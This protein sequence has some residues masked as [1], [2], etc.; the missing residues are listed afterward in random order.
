MLDPIIAAA[1]PDE[2]WILTDLG[3]AA[4]WLS[5]DSRLVALAQPAV[6]FPKDLSQAGTWTRN[7][8]GS[9]TH[10][11][12]DSE[13]GAAADTIVADGINGNHYILQTI[14]TLLSGLATTF[15]LDVKHVDT[16]WVLLQIAAT[17]TSFDILNGV[18]G[19]VAV[20]VTSR[21]IVPLGGGWYRITLTSTPASNYI[22]FQLLAA[23]SVA[24]NTCSTSV[25]AYNARCTQDRVAQSSDRSTA[26]KHLVQATAANQPQWV[27]SHASLLGRPVLQFDDTDDFLAASTAADWTFLHDGTGCTML[28]ALRPTDSGTDGAM[29]AT[30][31][32]A[33]TVRG[34]LL[35]YDGASQRVQYFLADGAAFIVAVSSAG[36]SVLRG[37]PHVISARYSESATPKYSVRC[38]GVEVLSG[39]PTAAP[40]ASAPAAALR[41]GAR[42]D[43]ATPLGGQVSQVAVFSRYLDTDTLLRVEQSFGRRIGVAI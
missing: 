14:T 31:G 10:G 32:H 36:N 19:S 41:V 27:A 23:D 35:S 33:G 39:S 30:G 38:D 15:S 24:A 18:L 5:D 2:D 40:S 25:V 37:V 29:L 20:G 42:T 12:A 17:Y 21:S 6:V 8:I 9:V 16:R 7:R 28:I 3:G 43:G 13:G 1:L 11:A 4:L 34:T 22:S 26:A